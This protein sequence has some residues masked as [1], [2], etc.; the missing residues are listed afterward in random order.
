MKITES[1]SREAYE[2]SQTR[3]AVGSEQLRLA[4]RDAAQTVLNTIGPAGGFQLWVSFWNAW[5]ANRVYAH[6]DILPRV[7]IQVVS[8]RRVTVTF[9][10]LFIG[11]SIGTQ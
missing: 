10:W 3:I 2:A 1:A 8:L 7:T 9:A 5:R 4:E 11:I 6:I